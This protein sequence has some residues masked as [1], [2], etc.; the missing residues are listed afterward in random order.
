MVK[1]LNRRTISAY[2]LEEPRKELSK[3]SSLEPSK[4]QVEKP[5]EGPSKAPREGQSEE[6]RK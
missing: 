5:S 4:N 3:T 1:L 2:S 6:L